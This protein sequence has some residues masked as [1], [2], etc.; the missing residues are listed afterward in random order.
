MHKDRL[1]E[2]TNELLEELRIGGTIAIEHL[3]E[4]HEPIQYI[5]GASGDFSIPVTLEPVSS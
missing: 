2:L 1:G 3:Y 4:L 5:C